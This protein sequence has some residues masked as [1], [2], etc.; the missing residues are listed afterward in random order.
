[1]ISLVAQA[2]AEQN[3]A[4]ADAVWAAGAAAVGWGPSARHDAA[5][6]LARRGADPATGALRAAAHRDG[7]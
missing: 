2:Q 6:E 5:K 1:V 3:P 7:R 4:R